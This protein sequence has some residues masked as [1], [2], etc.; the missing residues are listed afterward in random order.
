MQNGQPQ[1]QIARHHIQQHARRR[2]HDGTQRR[3]PVLPLVPAVH[4][5]VKASFGLLHGSHS[6]LGAGLRYFDFAIVKNG[7][8]LSRRPTP[9]AFFIVASSFLQHF[10]FY[11]NI[12]ALQAQEVRDWW[13]CMNLHSFDLKLKNF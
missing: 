4:A 3:G 5:G 9:N 10:H 13:C 7:S 12:F 6:F 11:L 2:L 8:L 1:Q